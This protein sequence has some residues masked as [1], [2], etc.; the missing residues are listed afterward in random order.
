MIG[1]LLYQLQL[2]QL[3]RSP[4]LGHKASPE[5]LLVPIGIPLRGQHAIARGQH[6]MI[7]SDAQLVVAKCG[8][9]YLKISAHLLTSLVLY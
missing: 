1:S 6:A 9:T 3:L 5:Y 8:V 7:Q 4:T 2:F